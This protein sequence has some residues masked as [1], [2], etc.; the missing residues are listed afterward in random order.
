MGISSRFFSSRLVPFLLCG[1]ASRQVPT[2]HSVV[3]GLQ[4]TVRSGACGRGR[5]VGVRLPSL[6]GMPFLHLGTSPL[7]GKIFSR[8]P[9]QPC[10][11]PVDQG[12]VH[13]TTAWD[14]KQRAR[15]VKRQ[16]G[17]WGFL[18]GGGRGDLLQHSLSGGSRGIE[19]NWSSQVRGLLV[20]ALGR[21]Q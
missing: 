21:P 8:G 17:K 18:P 4:F 20:A 10:R 2:K 6:C 12:L 5:C 13:Q 9:L 7:C 11:E 3:P 1:T 19:P 14:L 15:D 16:P